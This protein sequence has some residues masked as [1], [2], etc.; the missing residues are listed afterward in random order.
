MCNLALSRLGN[1]GSIENIDTPTKPAEVVFA[2]WW[3]AA[4]RM[5][6]KEMIPNFALDRR[7]L[8]PDAVAPAFGYGKRFEYPSDCV[9][10]LGFG[11]IQNKKNSYSIEGNWILTDDYDEDAEDGS[12]SLPIRFVKDETDVTKYTPEFIDALS[13]FLAYTV[14]MEIT[15]DADKQVYLE[16]IINSKK[17]VSSAINSQENMPIRLNNSKFKAAR[18]THN[19]QFNEKK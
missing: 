2:K 13:W 4:R 6:L 14:N 19:P 9:R 15:Q 12:V 11:E 18:Q 17:A 7:I 8:A 10:V 1:Y 5:A 3:D 16:K